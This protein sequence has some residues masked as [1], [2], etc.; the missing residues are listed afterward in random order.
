MSETLP[1]LA[2][3]GVAASRSPRWRV[4]WRLARPFSLTAAVVPIAVGTAVAVADGTFYSFALFG[5]M[6]LASILIQIATNMFNEYYD[7]KRGLDNQD[8]VGI[9]GAIVRERTAPLA[10]FGAAIGCFVVA[11]GLGL[12]I[13]ART[14]PMVFVVG[15]ACAL[16]GY[17]YTGGPLPVAYTP[18]GEIE[19]FVFMGPVM[20]GLAYF[21]QAGALSSPA[22]WASAPIA[23]LVAAILLGNNIRDIVADRRAGRSTLPI[24][25]GKT[26]AVV[27]YTI[28]IGAAFVATVLATLARQLPVTVLAGLVTAPLALRLIRLYGTSEGPEQL[29]AGVRGSA[30]LHGRFGLLFALGIWVGPLVPSIG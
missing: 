10:V 11:L 19:V 3:S 1:H 16:A 24:V 21:I 20:V 27:I 17:L 18:L 7:F 26:G 22:L 15:T 29:D 9:A 12:L 13:V 25:F 8:T 2:S 14:D 28:L 23:C 5:A 6:L 4:W 30:A